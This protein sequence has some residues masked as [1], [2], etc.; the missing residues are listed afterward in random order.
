MIHIRCEC[1]VNCNETC[2]NY[3]YW[4]TKNIPRT[5]KCNGL[6]IV[7]EHVDHL[8][9]CKQNNGEIRERHDAIVKDI[10]SL[11]NNAGL[12]FTDAGLGE[13]RTVYHDDYKAADGC[14]RVL[15]EKP[16]HINVGLGGDSSIIKHYA[17]KKRERIKKDKYLR[18]CQDINT[19]FMPLAFEIYGAASDS[20]DKL[21]QS[22]VSK[23][24]ERTLFVPYHVLLF[25]WRKRIS[26]TLQYY[27]AKITNQAYLKLTIAVE[28][29]YIVSYDSV[30]HTCLQIYICCV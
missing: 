8:L 3:P 6:K 28:A 29:T 24:S 12:Q 11:V 20:V 21:I 15:H 13:L 30:D 18:R 22:L 2:H 27:I 10:K 1:H 25:Y 26:Y 14:I 4:G 5:C 19:E 17:I 7:D 9:C 16:L 23:V